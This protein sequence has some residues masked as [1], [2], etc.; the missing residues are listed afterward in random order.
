[1][2]AARMMISLVPRLRVLVA[3]LALSN[4]IHQIVPLES[5]VGEQVYPFFNLWSISFV[6]DLRRLG[7]LLVVMRRLLD[8]V[9]YF[10]RKTLIG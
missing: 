6:H 3:S 8:E 1:M 10:L 2:S 4:D 7:Y 5:E 9:E